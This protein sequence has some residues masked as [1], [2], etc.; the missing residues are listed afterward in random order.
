NPLLER[1]TSEEQCEKAIQN[2]EKKH[3]FLCFRQLK[4]RVL[5]NDILCLFWEIQKTW[6]KNLEVWEIIT[7]FADVL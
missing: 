6:G 2:Y 3:R 7:T 4:S 1:Y 5:S